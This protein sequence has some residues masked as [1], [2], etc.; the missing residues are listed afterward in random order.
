MLITIA[1]IGSAVKGIAKQGHQY[2]EVCGKLRVN[3]PVFN[4]TGCVTPME[5]HCASCTI[6]VQPIGELP[7]CGEFVNF[8]YHKYL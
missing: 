5:C 1:V 7:H 3:H 6:I 8:T 2:F 4:S